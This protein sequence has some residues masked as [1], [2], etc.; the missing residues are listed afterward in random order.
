V[1]DW[2][3]LISIIVILL[4]GLLV[5]S[6]RK[7]IE[8]QRIFFP[9]LYFVVYRTKW[10]LRWMDKVGRRAPRFWGF[11]FNIGI[12]FGFI[13]MGWICY[14]LITSTISLILQ[15]EAAPGIM[16]VLPI[17]IKGTIAVPF[18][19]WIISIFVIACVHEFSHGIASRHIGVK[20]KSTGLAALCFFIPIIPAAFVEP[21]EQKI[22]KAS[23]KKQLKVFAAGPLANIVTA[24]IVL[25]ALFAVDPLLDP[26]L[27]E[28]GV[29]VNRLSAGA[30]AEIS[31]MKEGDI[32]TKIGDTEIIE[33]KD[34]SDAMKDVSPGD[35]LAII[36]KTGTFDAVLE[37]SPQNPEKGYLGVYPKQVYE[38]TGWLPKGALPIV[39][40]FL[41]LF[42]WLFF[43]NI[44]IG[45]FNLLPI[46][47]LDGGRMLNVV[48]KKF[49]K[50]HI[51]RFIS[52]FFF[53]I[54]IVNIFAG[55]MK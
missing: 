5:W 25:L 35:T 51:Y 49:N 32:I 28:S 20:V 4:I 3:F 39:Q 26:V 42:A 22:K 21:D 46:G 54:V 30:P 52:T 41:G 29:S 24:F 17:E 23:V 12:I 37:K 16:P 47:P 31:G 34:F 10:G 45:V 8:T 55:F 11:V 6:H 19:Y 1:I 36:T 44:G 33:V 38:A 18:L 27:I 14:E 50:L 43:L 48:C 13:A 40:W 2:Q 7:K 53:L 15:P 9:I